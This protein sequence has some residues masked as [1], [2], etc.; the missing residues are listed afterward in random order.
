MGG[1]LSLFPRGGGKEKV[2]LFCRIRRPQKGS[3]LSCR[4]GG[5]KR[6]GNCQ[7]PQRAAEIVAEKEL[8]YGISKEGSQGFGHRG[9]MSLPCKHSP[10]LRGEGGDRTV[11]AGPPGRAGPSSEG[12]SRK[13]FVVRK[14][15]RSSFPKKGRASGWP[16][17]EGG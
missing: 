3:Q 7:V 4:I 17:G 11:L 13:D 9:R 1:P 10:H 14:G 8:K 2:L 16:T 15:K 12:R 6:G 5:K